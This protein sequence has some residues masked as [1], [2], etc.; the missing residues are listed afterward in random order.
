MAARRGCC[1]WDVDHASWVVT[2][3]SPEEHD[4]YDKTFEE[5]L[6]WCLVWLMA[7]ELG[8]G[9]IGI[10]VGNPRGPYQLQRHRY[11]RNRGQLGATWRPRV[12]R[13]VGTD[14]SHCAYPATLGTRNTAYSDPSEVQAIHSAG[15]NSP[16]LDV[17][18]AFSETET[19]AASRAFNLLVIY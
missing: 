8:K 11:R 13:A 12:L 16:D 14:I 1:S 18:L 17:Y 5:A 4:F 10:P 7:A 19:G 15:N 2:L 3:H 6:A 9:C